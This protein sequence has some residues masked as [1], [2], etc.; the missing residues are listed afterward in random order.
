[1]GNIMDALDIRGCALGEPEG[2]LWYAGALEGAH[3]QDEADVIWN[4]PACSADVLCGSKG[5]YRPLSTEHSG[6]MA[7]FLGGVTTGLAAA[8]DQMAQANAQQE[9]QNDARMQQAAN[10]VAANNARRAQQGNKQDSTKSYA[11]T[12]SNG[13]CA[14]GNHRYRPSG[15]HITM[16]CFAPGATQPYQVWN[17]SGPSQFFMNVPACTRAQVATSPVKP[18][19]QPTASTYRIPV[20]A[21]A[22]VR[23]ATSVCPASGFY[24]QQTGDV[25]LGTPC[26]PGQPINL[27]NLNGASGTSPGL[28]LRLRRRDERRCGRPIC[29]QDAARNQPVCAALLWRAQ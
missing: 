13:R 9:A 14:Q 15:S 11:V 19:P 28:R 1:M 2:C 10:L 21:T 12:L 16:Q 5:T 23:V 24:M 4:L 18:A 29:G 17:D 22:P 25:S 7:A 8:T 6:T 27:N 26:T 3:R 20:A